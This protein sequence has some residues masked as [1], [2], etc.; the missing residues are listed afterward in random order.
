MFDNQ[1]QAISTMIVDNLAIDIQNSL[2]ILQETIL[3]SVKKN[4]SIFP[5]SFMD[6][7][8]TYMTYAAY[9]P[10]VYKDYI[11]NVKKIDQMDISLMFLFGEYIDS[12]AFASVLNLLL[13]QNGFNNNWGYLRTGTTTD[14]NFVVEIKCAHM[15]GYQK[16]ASVLLDLIKPSVEYN[17]RNLDN[18]KL[19]KKQYKN[20]IRRW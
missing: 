3:G 15:I 14:R 20:N 13:R 6:F 10:S 1:K 7:R 9:N 18:K 2:N 19:K 11:E 4:P 12:I 8:A 5:E 17:I 16:V